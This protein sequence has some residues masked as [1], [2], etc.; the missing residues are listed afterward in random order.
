MKENFIFLQIL[1]YCQKSSNFFDSI[2]FSANI[3]DLIIMPMIVVFDIEEGFVIFELSQYRFPIY[4]V[5][6]IIIHGFELESPF[7]VEH[8]M[9]DKF[10]IFIEIG[11]MCGDWYHLHSLFKLLVLDFMSQGT[12]STFN[13]L[14]RKPQKSNL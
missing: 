1:L 2:T 9:V 7:L 5:E 10:L 12:Q 11:Y 3:N 14:Q 6:L 13:F 4:N 8:E